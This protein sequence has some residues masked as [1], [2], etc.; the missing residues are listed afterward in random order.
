MGVDLLTQRRT[1][2]AQILQTQ[3]IWARSFLSWGLLH[4]IFSTGEKKHLDILMLKVCSLC[5]S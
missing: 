1:R 2:A 3:S 4:L 5:L